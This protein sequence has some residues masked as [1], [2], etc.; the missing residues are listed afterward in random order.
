MGNADSKAIRRMG[1]VITAG[2]TLSAEDLR[3]LADQRGQSPR[4]AALF[5]LLAAERS[6]YK[7]QLTETLVAET[8]TVSSLLGQ[9][10]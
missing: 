5:S 3:A 4:N 2:G 10:S 6:A 9:A 7:P 1:E 8:I